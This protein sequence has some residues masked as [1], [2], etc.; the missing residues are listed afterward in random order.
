MKRYNK[1]IFKGLFLAGLIGLFSSCEDFLTRDKPNASTDDDFW[2]TQQECESALG[3][4]KLWLRGDWGGDEIG[5]V[6]Q[7]G[8]SDNVYFTGN[9]D[10]RIQQLGNGSLVPPADN[11]NPG[12]WEY[13]FYTWNQ[14]YRKIRNCCRLLDNIDNAYFT[15]ESERDRMKA[16]A[17]VWRAWYHIRLLNWYGRNDGIPYVDKALLPSEIYMA[18]T[19]VNECLDRINAELDEVINSEALPFIWD[20]GRRDRMSRS[21]AL[22]L[23]MDVNLQ[24]KR[25][26]IAK[27][28]A[29]ELI[30][31]GE[32]ELYY[33]TATD[34]NPGKNYRDLFTYVGKQNKERIL[35]K[36]GGS[37]GIFSRC[38][39]GS[40]GGQGVMNV[41]KSFIDTY[42]T[43]D[44]QTIQSLS[45]SE[46][47]AYEKDPYHGARDP[48]LNVSV[49]VPG[50]N[51]GLSNYT[52]S[53]FNPDC[54]DYIGRNDGI[55]SGYMVKKFMTEDDRGNN[56]QGSL[57]FVI[58]RYAEVLLD[59]VEC[60]VE[61]GDWDDPKVKEYIDAIRVRSGMPKMDQT[62]YNSEEKVRELYRRERR[63]ELCFE[64]KRYDD[65]RRWGIGNDVMN[66]PIYGAWNPDTQ[67]FIKL[68][69]RRCTFPKFDSWPIPQVVIDTNKDVVMEQNPGWN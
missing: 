53:P 15:N 64:G 52:F 36:G 14:C 6:F 17:K 58:Y 9:F 44:G 27:A 33:S 46:R 23:K 1:I 60:L 8:A 55:R 61:T 49:F 41:L 20:E 45:T 67:S 40:F 24:F 18:R 16:E 28:A 56:G 57:D 12:P 31:S 4:C 30:K 7:D 19:P 34:N 22:T 42:E 21:I 43:I 13:Q 47:E 26:D 10:V 54:G 39:S 25:Y 48:R 11:N 37:S 35:Y 5:M 59:Y 68:E 32:F 69:E 3:T 65:I 50:D 63:V 38:M 66:G 2:K 62:V 29:W 51:T